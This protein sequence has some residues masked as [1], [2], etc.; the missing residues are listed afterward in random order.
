[1]AKV[2]SLVPAV[3]VLA[4][5]FNNAVEC[6]ELVQLGRAFENNFQTS[7]LKLDIARLRLSR[8]GK[9]LGLDDNVQN[10]VSLEGPFS[11]V[12]NI[13]L[14]EKAL[15]QIIELFADTERISIKYESA[16]NPQD[17][18]LAVYNPQIDLD[19]AIA[20]LHEKLRQL[21]IE[22]QNRS[23][24]RQKAKWAL[25][26]KKYFR[27]L[28]ANITELVDNLVELSPATQQSQRNLCDLE[29]SAIG[30]G[31]GRSVLEELAAAQ[32]KLLEQAMTKARITTVF[33]DETTG[34]QMGVNS[35]SI[36]THFLLPGKFLLPL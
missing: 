17:G 9:S 36:N 29:V 18:S 16:T 34:L 12:S 21:A 11:S 27:R 10:R 25:Y 26:E 15:G 14:A 28:I 13:Q 2:A 33:G 20:N 3:L 19:P 31:E 7:Q 24:I 22:R 6:F 32:D 8:W 5:L 1:M 23:S 35:G 4:G 30:E